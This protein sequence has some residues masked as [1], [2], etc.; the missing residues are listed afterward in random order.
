[1]AKAN[2]SR[3]D[4]D[5]TIRNGPLSVQPKLLWLFEQRVSEAFIRT[6]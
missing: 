6:G 3:W 2:S 5:W 4:H 1:M